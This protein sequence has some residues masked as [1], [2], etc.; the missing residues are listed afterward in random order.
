MGVR[1][2]RP[3]TRSQHSQDDGDRTYT[4]TDH[5]SEHTRDM[6]LVMV[7]QIAQMTDN[8]LGVDTRWFYYYKR[9]NAGRRCSCA[10]GENNSP[11]SNC[12]VCYGV[13]IVGG[14]DKYGTRS[15]T[16]DVTYPGFSFINV[17]TRPTPLPSALILEDSATRGI[18]RGSLKLSN[19]AGYMDSFSITAK[20]NVQVRVRATGTTTWQIASTVVLTSLLSS[21]SLD[22]EMQLDRDHPTDPSP[23]FL[24]MYVRYGLLPKDEIK[25]PG[26]LPP[27]T[28][29][30]SLQEYGY[31][32]QFG[33][34]QIVMGSSGKNR[35]NRIT[36]FTID[37][38]LY[39]IERGRHWK[40]TE[41]KPNYALGFFTSF[42]LTAR[43]VQKYERYKEFPV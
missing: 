34:V 28:E 32:E 9:R 5:M 27:N 7:K 11:S 16:L 36:T 18:I 20:G 3:N 12:K 40:I 6:A 19:N 17:T 21:S 38:F 33:T 1:Q 26:D 2:Y 29:S 41:V 22:F 23:V 4:R 24:K 14:Y 25:I 15:E 35:T 39:Y 13:G 43:W 8:A 30:V 10:L 31:D 37:D 42:D